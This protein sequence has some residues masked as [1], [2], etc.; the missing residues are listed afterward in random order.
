MVLVGDRG[1]IT[2][3]RIRDDLKPAGLDWISCLRAPAIQALAADERAVA[4]VAVRRARP[5]RDQRPRDV[6]G[7]TADR[8]PQSG[9]RGRAG[10]QARGSVSRHRTRIDPG[11]RAGR[12]QELPPQER[13]RDRHGGRRRSQSQEDGQALR[14]RDCR[15]PSFLPATHRADRAK[16]RASTASMSSAPACRQSISTPPQTVQAYKD[17]S[18]VERAFRS[19]KT[20]DLEIRPIRHWTAQR[21]RAHVFLCMLAYHV[22]WHAARSSC[23]ALVPRHR[24]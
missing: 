14:R 12:P 19:L 6:S 15:R 23:A 10:A 16:R 21:V 8:V 24:A 4:A 11:A 13:R 18:R 5:G 20:V 1:M 22:E 2:S 3:A 17:L 7:R 9:S